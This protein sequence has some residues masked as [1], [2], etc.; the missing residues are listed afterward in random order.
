MNKDDVQYKVIF[1]IHM[2]DRLIKAGFNITS[3]KPSRSFQGRAA[4]I[5]EETPELIQAMQDLSHKNRK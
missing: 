2:A 4:F 5:F 3:V 1:N